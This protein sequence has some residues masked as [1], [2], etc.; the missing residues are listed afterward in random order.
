[1]ESG[2]ITNPLNRRMSIQP[3][4]CMYTIRVPLGRRITIEVIKGNSI[5]PTCALTSFN[6]FEGENEKLIVSVYVL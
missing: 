6:P 1:M 3:T 2:E 5:V 4:T